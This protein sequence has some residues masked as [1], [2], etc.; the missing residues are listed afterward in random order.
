MTQYFIRLRDQERWISLFKNN[1]KI[2]CEEALAVLYTALVHAKT[3]EEMKTILTAIGKV[4]SILA[5]PMCAV[6]RSDLIKDAAA[7]NESDQGDVKSEVFQD[8]W[9]MREVLRDV[10]FPLPDKKENAEVSHGKTER[11]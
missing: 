10:Y 2:F 6:K 11:K 5:G 3:V 9:E 4:E 8:F 7:E 1:K